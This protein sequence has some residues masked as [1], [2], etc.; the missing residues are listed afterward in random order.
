MHLVGYLY[1]VV[2]LCSRRL[3]ENGTPL[4]E[5]VAVRYLS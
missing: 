1:E 5:H 4:P 2:L 3:P